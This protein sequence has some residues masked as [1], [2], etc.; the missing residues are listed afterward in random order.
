M[1]AV[2]A[3]LL[4]LAPAAAHLTPNSQIALD[5]GETRVEASLIIPLGELRY[6]EPSLAWRDP[7]ALSQWITRH[8][9][10]TAA[11][12]RA[13]RIE[14]TRAQVNGDPSPDVEAHIVIHPPAGV[15]VR[16]FRLR[17]TGLI[18]QLPNHFVLVM[19]HSDFAGGHLADRPRML[20]ALRENAAEM[21]VD[22]GPGSAWRG[23]AGAIGLGMHHIAEGHD[24]LLFLIVLLLPAPMLAQ[25]RRWTQYAG[26]RRTARTLAAI[27]TAFTIGHSI[28]LIGGA[29]FGWRLAAAPVEMAIALSI[30]IS[31]VHAWRPLFAGREAWVAGGFGLVH[32]LAFATIIGRFGIE[33]LQKAQ[34][35]LGFNLGIELV[36][37]AIVCA[38]LPSLLILS[39]TES[40]RYLRTGAAAFCA[41]AA[42]TW[43]GARM[44]ALPAAAALAMEAVISQL[45]WVTLALS[46]IVLVGWYLGRRRTSSPLAV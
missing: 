12:G 21:T 17:Y 19:L 44:G 24:H 11:D 4:P 7:A 39:R 15:R 43:I 45:G 14:V 5:I 9:A 10:V 3:L 41:V 1:L 42:A 13:W 40:Y 2:S 23:F 46:L 28:T 35:I 8:I 30:L 34:S 38:A 16:S 20:G 6:A 37:L 31:A 22:R 18:D 33:P 25:S 27:V 26:L 29:F 36:Q 32:G